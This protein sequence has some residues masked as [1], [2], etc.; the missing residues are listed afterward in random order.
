MLEVCVVGIGALGMMYSYL[1]E[2]T[3][4]VR[5]T[6]VCRSNYE[7]LK[8]RG[9]DLE[10][11]KYGA[12]KRFQPFR[13][14]NST[15]EA[16][17]RQYDY[18]L[19]AAK[20]VPDL[21]PTTS[22]LGPLIPCTSTFVLIQNGI[23]IHEGPCA[24]APG[25]TVITACAWTDA[26]AVE[27]G[28]LVR[29]GWI[30]RIALGI[31]WPEKQL[32]DTTKALWQQKLERIV[33]LFKAVGS[34]FE[35]ADDIDSMK[36]TK[37]LWN[38][39]FSVFCTLTRSSCATIL[40]RKFKPVTLPVVQ[41]FM[42]EA[43]VI[44]RAIGLSLPDDALQYSL[45]ITLGRYD[46]EVADA[47]DPPFTPVHFKPSMQVDL[48]SGRPMEVEGIVGSVVKKGREAGIPCP[49]LE[50]AYASL[51]LLQEPL[52]AGRGK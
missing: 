43:V 7:I 5:V 9:I 45:N 16:A 40:N 15:A 36:W 27:G 18:I 3:G 12:V 31:H 26:T 11:E 24:A 23:G 1:L 21:I 29:H 6:A 17:D 22:I 52:L 35:V 14:V 41:G 50:T 28:T 33:N 19:C 8:N 46:Q 13:V 10:S 34:D 48:E 49:R 25:A 37:N 30:D 32:D 44:G 39:G 20:F 4:E 42:E 47:A 38:I 2:K 51:L